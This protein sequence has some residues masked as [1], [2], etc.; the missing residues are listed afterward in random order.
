[1]QPEV[2]DDV[3]T[4]RISFSVGPLG[5]GTCSVQLVTNEGVVIRLLVKK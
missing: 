4:I 5:A 3:S 2:I 1:M